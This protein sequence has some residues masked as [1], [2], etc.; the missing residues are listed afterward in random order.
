MDNIISDIHIINFNDIHWEGCL[1]IRRPV[2]ANTKWCL[3]KQNGNKL[4]PP[5]IPNIHTHIIILL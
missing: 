3:L 2:E 4:L 5:I 1:Y